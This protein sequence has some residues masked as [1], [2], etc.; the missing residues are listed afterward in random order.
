[1]GNGKNSAQLDDEWK[2]I[3]K[4]IFTWLGEIHGP[5]HNEG[6]DAQQ[7]PQRLENN[8]FSCF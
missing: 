4:K 8:H 5:G 3:F 1:M 2:R 7:E 6:R